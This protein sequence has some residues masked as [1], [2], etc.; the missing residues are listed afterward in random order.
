MMQLLLPDKSMTKTGHHS[1]L[2]ISCWLEEGL[3]LS[4]TGIKLHKDLIRGVSLAQGSGEP[5]ECMLSAAFAY[6][7]FSGSLSHSDWHICT[8]YIYFFKEPIFP[9]QCEPHGWHLPR[10]KVPAAGK[11]L[12]S[13]FIGVIYTGV[14]QEKRWRDRGRESSIFPYPCFLQFVWYLSL[15]HNSVWGFQSCWHQVWWQTCLACVKKPEGWFCLGFFIT[16]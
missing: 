13:W 5:A 1:Q 8:L 11:L 6:L 2:K 10:S 7:G 12:F 4:V 14:G 16:I 3:R 15:L 9:N